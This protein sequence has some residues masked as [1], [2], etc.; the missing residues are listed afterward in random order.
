MHCAGLIPLINLITSYKLQTYTVD[1]VL[2]VYSTQYCNSLVRLSYTY[3]YYL[4]LFEP[5]G[6]IV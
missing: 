1:I 6:R 2:F 5:S 3:L 4:D